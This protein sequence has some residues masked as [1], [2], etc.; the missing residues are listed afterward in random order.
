MSKEP[1]DKS[2]TGRRNFVKAAASTSALGAVAISGVATAANRYKD[3]RGPMPTRVL[4]ATGEQVPILHLGTSQR[5]DQRYDK[6]MHRSFQ[7]GVTWFDTALSYGWG[8]SHTA[9]ANFIGQM[10]DRKKL[11]L[12]SKSG[13]GSVGGLKSGLNEALEE[14][15]TD[16]VDLFLMH[17][18]DDED[19]L[20]PEFL[21]AGADMKKS[22]KTRFFGFSCHDGNVAGLMEKS[23][24][25]GGIDA[26]LFRY[27]FRRYGDLELNRAIDACHKAGIGLMAMKTMGSVPAEL[28]AV[29]EFESKQFTLGQAKLKSVLGDER[30]ASICSEMD[31]VQRVRENVAAAKMEQPLTAGEAHQLNRLAALTSGYACNGCKQHCERAAGGLAISDQLRFLMYHDCYAGKATRA[32]QLFAQLH[33]EQ[34]TYDEQR[35]AAA[36]AV[37]PQGIDLVSRIRDAHAALA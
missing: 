9:I 14:L 11:F 33:A 25:V 27:S 8:S 16:Y 7:A 20:E 10:G 13:S 3:T 37:C 35:L 32:R 6:V 34:R 22:G 15:Q 1:M 2:T 17:G 36:A 29:A 19:M 26:I 30:I 21:R 4:G 12:T 24:R 31:S 5:L 28:E 23:A 18:I